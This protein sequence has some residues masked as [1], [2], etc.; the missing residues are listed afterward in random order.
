MR[1]ESDGD[2]NNAFLGVVSTHYSL[3]F[4]LVAEVDAYSSSST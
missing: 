1:P 3:V 4:D 2:I